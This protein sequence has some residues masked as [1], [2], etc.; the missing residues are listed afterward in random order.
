MLLCL[1][2]KELLFQAITER[3]P[4]FIQD[5]VD[6]YLIFGFKIKKLSNVLNYPVLKKCLKYKALS[7]L[8]YSLVS[9]IYFN[10]L[11]VTFLYHMSERKKNENSY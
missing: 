7:P 11:S 6:P 9:R 10:I 4:F 2:S 5:A 1:N 3:S 8:D